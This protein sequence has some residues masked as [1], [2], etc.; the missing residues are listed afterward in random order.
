MFPTGEQFKQTLILALLIFVLVFVY[1]VYQHRKP[2]FFG[3]YQQKRV[4]DDYYSPNCQAMINA[5][6]PKLDDYPTKEIDFQCEG[7]ISVW[8]E[9]K[10]TQFLNSRVGERVTVED[11]YLTMKRIQN[12]G[13]ENRIVFNAIFIAVCALL[14]SNALLMLLSIFTKLRRWQRKRH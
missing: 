10:L 7:L 12:I 9:L 1:G 13:W 6:P 3:Q 5:N 11:I 14:L 2:D 4:V 8:T